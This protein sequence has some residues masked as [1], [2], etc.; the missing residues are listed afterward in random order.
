M[1]NKHECSFEDIFEDKSN[2]VLV[3]G[4]GNFLMG[5]EGIGVHIV[6]RM[7]KMKL[8]EYIDVFG[9]WNRRIFSYERF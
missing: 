2:K 5:D 6:K 4:I 3:L 8:P 1:E 9:W 7:E